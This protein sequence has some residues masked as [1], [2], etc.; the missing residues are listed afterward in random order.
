MSNVMLGNLPGT[1]CVALAVTVFQLQL[2]PLAPLLQTHCSTIA[3]FD[4]DMTPPT[5]AE[6]ITAIPESSEA[7]KLTSLTQIGSFGAELFGVDYI[8]HIC[9]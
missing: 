2:H 9:Q 4:I 3:C 6:L 7:P 5:Y 1:A 8:G